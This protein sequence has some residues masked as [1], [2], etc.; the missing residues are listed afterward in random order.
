MSIASRR[1][2][3]SFA[4]SEETSPSHGIRLQ[5]S[6]ATLKHETLKNS[7]IVFFPVHLQQS[8]RLGAA[9]WPRGLWRTPAPASAPPVPAATPAHSEEP[10]SAPLLQ[11]PCCWSPPPRTPHRLTPARVPWD[12]RK[13][14]PG[15]LWEQPGPG[16]P[17]G[18]RLL[19]RRVSMSQQAFASVQGAAKRKVLAVG[20]S[21]GQEGAVSAGGT[22][23][24]CPAP[25]IAWATPAQCS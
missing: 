7:L 21:P 13:N 17:S 10:G 6:I 4:F 14:L 11:P 2:K 12:H 3:T 25:T 15:K 22:S 18:T 5:H 8:P 9:G 19:S 1:R 23:C 24:C 16:W 20:G